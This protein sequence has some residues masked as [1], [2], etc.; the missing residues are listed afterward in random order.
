[1]KSLIENQSHVAMIVLGNLVY[2]LCTNISNSLNNLFRSVGNNLAGRIDSAPNVLLSGNYA[3]N[4][5]NAK[6]N[7][8]TIIVQEIRESFATIKT[9]KSFGTDNISS[10]FLKLALPFIE[11]SLAFLF[12][13]SIETSKFPDASKSCSNFQRWR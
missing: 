10:Y 13:K 3:I 12:N 6:F 11:N 5:N 8:E 1:M 2:R 7:L 4:K 9:A